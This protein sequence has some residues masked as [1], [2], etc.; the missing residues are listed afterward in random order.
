MEF[1][2]LKQLSNLPI[3]QWMLSSLRVNIFRVSDA[4]E[5]LDAV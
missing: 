1:G 4:G 5:L 3:S 2:S